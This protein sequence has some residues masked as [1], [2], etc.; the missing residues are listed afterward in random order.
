MDQPA[1]PLPSWTFVLASITLGA[2]GA[3]A[4]FLNISIRPISWIG[5]A[6]SAVLIC[7]SVPVIIWTRRSRK[8]R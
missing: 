8:S 5:T 3:Y 1:A 2:F 7:S 4:L 6:A